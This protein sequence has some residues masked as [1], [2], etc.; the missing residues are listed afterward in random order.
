MQQP[1]PKPRTHALQAW[2]AKYGPWAIVTG[3]SDGIGREIAHCLAES[4]LWHWLLDVARC[5]RRWPKSS[6]RPTAS[7]RA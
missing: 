7:K 1:S 5:S 4:G 6:P 2:H 3:A